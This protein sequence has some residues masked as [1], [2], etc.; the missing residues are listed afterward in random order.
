MKP[1]DKGASDAPVITTYNEKKIGKTLYRVTNVY[2]GEIE[3]KKALEDLTVRKI[4]QAHSGEAGERSEGRPA[5]FAKQ[6]ERAENA[7]NG[8]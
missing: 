8:G 3:L 7:E 6:S 1:T 2:K 4:L 5:S